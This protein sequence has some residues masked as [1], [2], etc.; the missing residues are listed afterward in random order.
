MAA[1]AK[2]VTLPAWWALVPRRKWFTSSGMSSPPVGEGGQMEVDHIQAVEQ[3]PRNRP[4]R[5]SRSRS[6]L[7]ADMMRTSTGS[8][9]VLPTARTL[10][11]CRRAAASPAPATACRRFHPERGCHLGGPEQPQVFTDCPGESA[12]DV[13]EQFRF[14]QLF[15]QGAAVN[16]NKGAT[17]LRVCLV[18]SPASSS[19]PLPLAPVI[20]MLTSDPAT[21][22]TWLSILSITGLRVTTCSRHASTILAWV[23]PD[24]FR[25]ARIADSSTV[26][27][28]G[29]VR[30]FKYT[31]LG[32]GHRL[33]NCPLRRHDDD[34][35][36]GKKYRTW[37]NGSNPLA[38]S[39]QVGDPRS[40]GLLRST[41][42]ELLGSR[43][44]GDDLKPSASQPDGS[45]FSKLASSSHQQQA[46]W[47]VFIS[48]ACADGGFRSVMA[49]F[50][51]SKRF[52]FCKSFTCCCSA[53]YWLRS[54]SRL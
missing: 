21:W 17:P 10:R 24:C 6:R 19:L 35:E 2:L 37:V 4:D 14:Q 46:I 18:Y 32:G 50:S 8:L 5:I 53:S 25:A 15:G 9:T 16:G 36:S 44:G 20:R 41:L 54:S 3:V 45:S 22:R 48:P 33:G 51:L 23:A 34:R 27:S 47:H 38:P 52:S 1:G 11:S 26:L 49:G 39:M 7:V 31:H 30:E 29:L 28:T 43:G 42:Q 13:A 40:I 12:L